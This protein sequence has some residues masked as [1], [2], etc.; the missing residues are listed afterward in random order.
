M[1]CV[2]FFILTD[3]G[4]RLVQF[5]FQ[6]TIQQLAYQIWDIKNGEHAESVVQLVTLFNKWHM[7]GTQ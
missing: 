7:I 1:W 4:F 2:L 3:I 5:F 6:S